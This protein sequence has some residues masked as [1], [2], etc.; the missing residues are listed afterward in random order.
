MGYRSWPE[1]STADHDALRRTQE[2]AANGRTLPEGQ[3]SSTSGLRYAQV[4]KK[5]NQMTPRI[6][7]ASPVETVS[8]ANTEGPRSA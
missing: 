4:R 2:Q 5:T 7:T 6:R 3:I 1:D 8:R